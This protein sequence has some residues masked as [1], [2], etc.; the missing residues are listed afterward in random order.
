M[1][2][3][4]LNVLANLEQAEKDMN[5]DFRAAAFSITTLYK[6]SRYASKRAYST[7]YA[8]ACQDLLVM[9][10]QGVSAGGIAPSTSTNPDGSEMTIGKVMDWIEARLDAIKSRQEEEE[11]EWEKEKGRGGGRANVGSTVVA[12]STA[13]RTNTTSAKPSDSSSH[14]TQNGPSTNPQ[15]VAEHTIAPLT[16]HSPLSLNATNLTS[17]PSSPSPPPHAPLR[18][19]H[20]FQTAIRPIKSRALALRPKDMPDSLMSVNPSISSASS[21]TTFR[22]LSVHAFKDTAT[23]TSTIAG[24]ADSDAPSVTDFS[25]GAK[26]RHAVMMMLDSAG[27]TAVENSSPGSSSMSQSTHTSSA[28]GS[29][30]RRTRSTRNSA[31][32]AHQGQ[33][34][35]QVGDAMEVEDDGRERKRV[36]RR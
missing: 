27:G 7:G 31:L 35:S 17:R 13:H 19:I 8:A 24:L 28:S 9:I 11:E 2:S 15:R 23:P 1:E 26:R 6:S 29:S 36:T 22:P 16:P 34:Q 10:Q 33:V 25:A 3:L 32:G 4:N 21:D 14:P 20:H 12:P 5:S 30:R 18:P